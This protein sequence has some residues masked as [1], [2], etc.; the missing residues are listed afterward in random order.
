MLTAEDYTAEKDEI[1]IMAAE[2]HIMRK[3]CVIWLPVSGCRTEDQ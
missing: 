1:G 3:I 2:M